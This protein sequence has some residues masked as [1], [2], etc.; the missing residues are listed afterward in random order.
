MASNGAPLAS[1]DAD[2]K[3][4]L[5]KIKRQLASGSGRNLLQG[6]LLKRSETIMWVNDV[7]RILTLFNSD[8]GY[9]LVIMLE[10]LSIYKKRFL[11]DY[12]EERL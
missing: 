7:T 8:S 12:V 10:H 3:T 11:M 6:P 5:E 1:G 9:E 4:S 2:T